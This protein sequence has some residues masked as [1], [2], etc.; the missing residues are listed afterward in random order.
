MQFNARFGL[1]PSYNRQGE[2]F[3]WWDRRPCAPIYRIGLFAIERNSAL[4]IFWYVVRCF[5]RIRTPP[6]PR[7]GPSPPDLGL[8]DFVAMNSFLPER[9]DTGRSGRRET[10]AARKGAHHETFTTHSQITR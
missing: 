2:G 7:E 3:L 6:C 10:R 1:M 8:T 9:A 4:S 5:W